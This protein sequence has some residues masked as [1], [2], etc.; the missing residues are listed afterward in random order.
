MKWEE[1]EDTARKVIKAHPGLE[2][3][4]YAALLNHQFHEQPIIGWILLDRLGGATPPPASEDK[5]E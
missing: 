2:P 4:Q 3:E 5:N 1:I